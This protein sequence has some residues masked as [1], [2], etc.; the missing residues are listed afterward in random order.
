MDTFLGQ[1]S[2]I[3]KCIPGISFLVQA[4]NSELKQV[5]DE[6]LALFIIKQ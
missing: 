5:Q 6:I 4:V 1:R 2:W 3:G